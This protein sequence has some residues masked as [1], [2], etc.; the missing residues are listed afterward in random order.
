MFLSLASVFLKSKS[1]WTA[2][3]DPQFWGRFPSIFDL[4]SSYSPPP[5]YYNFSQVFKW[6]SSGE[7]TQKLVFPYQK[8]W[9]KKKETNSFQKK[10]FFLWFL[11][12]SS[13][14]SRCAWHALAYTDSLKPLPL[15]CPSQDGMLFCYGLQRRGGT[16]QARAA[17]KYKKKKKNQETRFFVLLFFLCLP[18]PPFDPATC[19]LPTSG[20]RDTQAKRKRE[21]GNKLTVVLIA[22]VLWERKL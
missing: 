4:V 17:L 18:S 12:G 9:Q 8:S 14:T 16:T 2:Q 1:S 6:W 3:V 10:P 15:T 13:R 21:D 20:L 7:N 22:V 19:C 11:S 5:A